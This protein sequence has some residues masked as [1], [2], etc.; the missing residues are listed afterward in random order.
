MAEN[1]DKL[2]Q[3]DGQNYL[4]LE[5][6]RKNNEAAHT[7]VWFVAENA[8][9]YI[10][11]VDSSAKVKRI[12]A[13]PKVRVV[14]CEVQGEPKGKWIPGIAQLL[15]AAESARVNELFDAK[16]GELKRQFEAQ[17]QMQGLTYATIAVSL[18]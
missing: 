6:Y 17:A 3:F 1:E 10:R 7:P 8:M 9:L 12:R 13:N 16:Y 5:T 4:N 15:N 2:A 11:T 18:Q 14:P